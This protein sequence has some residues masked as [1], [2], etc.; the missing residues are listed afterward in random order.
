MERDLTTFEDI[1]AIASTPGYQSILK[2]FDDEV[3]DIE[4]AMAEAKDATEG[5]RLLRQ[6]QIVKRI[7]SALEKYPQLIKT[8]LE[9]IRDRELL[10]PLYSHYPAPQARTLLEDYI[11]RKDKEIMEKHNL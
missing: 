11:A 10:E 2:I 5:L 8:E 3:A 4:L 9:Q 6:W 7:A 1:A